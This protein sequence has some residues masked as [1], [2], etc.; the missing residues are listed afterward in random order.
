M[1]KLKEIMMRM[2]SHNANNLPQTPQVGLAINE[3]L[4]F[5][6]RPP[7]Q[8]QCEQADN[9]LLVAQNQNKWEN[10]TQWD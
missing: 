3:I 5:R 1:T 9:R 10:Y 7:P 2:N 8:P 4:L 6:C